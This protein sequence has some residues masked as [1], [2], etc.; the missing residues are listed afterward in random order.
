MLC[1]ACKLWEL[2]GQ[3]L[4]VVLSRDPPKGAAVGLQRGKD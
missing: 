4:G 2:E 3:S 1:C